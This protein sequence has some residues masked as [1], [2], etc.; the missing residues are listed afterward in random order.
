MNHRPKQT[1]RMKFPLKKL[2]SL[3]S[4]TEGRQRKVHFDTFYTTV[5]SQDKCRHIQVPYLG[6]LPRKPPPIHAENQIQD[7]SPGSFG[8][9]SIQKFYGLHGSVKHDGLHGYIEPIEGLPHGYVF[10][11]VNSNPCKNSKNKHQKLS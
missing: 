1:L 10:A 8:L 7:M 9:T 11:D 5:S 2:S 3:F 4:L 6:I